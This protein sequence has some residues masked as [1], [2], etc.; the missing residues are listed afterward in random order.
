MQPELYGG[1]VHASYDLPVPST[2]GQ[3]AWW[4]QAAHEA[5]EA[6]A[7]DPI[8]PVHLNCPFEEPLTPS[9]RISATVTGEQP[10]DWPPPRPSA[11][12]DPDETDRLTELVSGKRGVV[13]IGGL[14]EH[15]RGE[16][17]FW[18]GL[19]GWPVLAEP[20]SGDRDPESA[21]AAGQV[22]IGGPWWEARPPEVVIQFGAYPTSRST[23]RL[24]ASADQL[25]VADRWHLDPDPDRLASWRLAVD[26]S[27]LPEALGQHPVL[28]RGIGIALTGEHT[29]SEIEDLW[30]GRIDPAPDEWHDVWN[31]AD[32]RA[33]DTMDALMD[34][35]DEPFEPRIARDVAGWVP[36][37]GR[38][39]VG[40]STPIRDLDLAMRPRRNLTVWATGE[41]AGSTGSCPRRW[42]CRS[43]VRSWR[44]SGTCRSSTTPE[45]P[46]GTLRATSTS[47]SSS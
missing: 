32:V 6:M 14:P 34:G 4:R 47:R 2:A 26:P 38:L 39:F 46:C 15:L 37:G 1:Y 28:Q 10:F 18:S 36:D 25:V 13:V 8:G 7:T 43:R 27:A 31:G 23:Q 41:R 20:T 5:L 30:H 45:R 21:L 35:W 29:E 11:E 33:R 19:M 22:L 12:L 40:N 17:H 44:S 42:A 9:K 24:V 3:E 16:S